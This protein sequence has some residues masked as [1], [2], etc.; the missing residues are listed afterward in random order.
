[1]LIILHPVSYEGNIGANCVSPAT[2]SERGHCKHKTVANKTVANR[3]P[4]AT[5][6]QDSDHCLFSAVHGLV[7]KLHEPSRAYLS[8]TLEKPLEERCLDTVIRWFLA[9]RS[10]VERIMGEFLRDGR[11]A[12]LKP[13][14]LA[15]FFEELHKSFLSISFT[16]K[17]PSPLSTLG[18]FLFWSCLDKN[19]HDSIVESFK[20]LKNAKWACGQSVVPASDRLKWSL[21]CFSQYSVEI[22]TT[23]IFK[24]IKGE[25]A[26]MTRRSR[27]EAVR[28]KLLVRLLMAK[29]IVPRS[30]QFYSQ[31]GPSCKKFNGLKISDRVDTDN[32]SLAVTNSFFQHIRDN[33]PRPHAL[34]LDTIS[35]I[36]SG[37][38]HTGSIETGVDIGTYA[39][40]LGF[41]CVS[42]KQIEE[43]NQ[44]LKST[45]ETGSGPPPATP[46][47]EGAE[48]NQATFGG[49]Q[50]E[51]ENQEPE[52]T[53]RGVKVN[54]ATFVLRCLMGERD[55]AAAAGEVTKDQ[56]LMLQNIQEMTNAF[57]KQ[58]ST[59]EAQ[60]E[61][62]SDI[63]QMSEE[64]LRRFKDGKELLRLKTQLARGGR[65]EWDVD[66]T[67]LT[68]KIFQRI[69]DNYEELRHL[70]QFHVMLEDASMA[71]PPTTE[72]APSNEVSR[73][74][75]EEAPPSASQ[76]KK[77]KSS[78]AVIVPRGVPPRLGPWIKKLTEGIPEDF[79]VTGGAP[80][81]A[82][83]RDHGHVKDADGLKILTAFLMIVKNSSSS[84]GGKVLT[85]ILSKELAGLNH[86]ADDHVAAA[87]AHLRATTNL[88]KNEFIQRLANSD[89]KQF[90]GSVG[91]WK[92]FFETEC[93]QLEEGTGEDTANP[94]ENRRSPRKATAKTK[95][96]A[97]PRVKTK[98]RAK[99]S[100][101]TGKDSDTTKVQDSAKPPTGVKTT[102]VKRKERGT[103]G[104]TTSGR[105][106]LHPG[107]SQKKQRKP[108]T[109]HSTL[110]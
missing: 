13:V 96:T 35:E 61:M 44:E 20:C 32:M 29:D 12:W 50:I 15:D 1:M 95:A 63:A 21:L 18:R 52:C 55:P 86:H 38:T 79:K 54:Q 67:E 42:G 9:T 62:A 69:A 25:M 97:K 37:K 45:G 40:G 10:D 78:V 5:P 60:Q 88:F 87:L 91:T 102:S 64:V 36:C 98:A 28:T 101:T 19:C 22:S 31:I 76:Q 26:L 84:T 27:Q 46:G 92:S 85:R 77:K 71:L 48:V 110:V 80:P 75:A 14:S 93:A 6:S 105:K 3:M 43:E 99:T 41:K 83:R 16:D 70:P 23:T 109:L 107:Q 49:K 74:Q 24:H 30:T 11:F 51:E 90:S 89:L 72:I 73:K 58:L 94:A 39:Q 57:S 17:H 59:V 4:T 7:M 34:A 81:A 104:D 47:M 82:L 53:K 100:A 103:R 106:K 2:A 56:Q 108:D 68:N 65:T 8:E 33:N 66:A